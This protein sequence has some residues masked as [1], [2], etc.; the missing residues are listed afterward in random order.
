MQE[1]FLIL[2]W[3][4]VAFSLLQLLVFASILVLKLTPAFS[5]AQFPFLPP[6]LRTLYSPSPPPHPHSGHE[7]ILA[8]PHGTTLEEKDL[9]FTNLNKPPH[10]TSSSPEPPDPGGGGGGVSSP[11]TPSTPLLFPPNFSNNQS[12][13]RSVVR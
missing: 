13:S 2:K 4:S 11:A 1:Y 9:I 10:S 6:S 3:S 12:H 8:V 5:Y 7:V